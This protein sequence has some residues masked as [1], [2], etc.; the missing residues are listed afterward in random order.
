MCVGNY[1]MELFFSAQYDALFN[2]LYWVALN[3]CQEAENTFW[4]INHWFVISSTPFL[5][6]VHLDIRHLAN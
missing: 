1:N 3:Y 5:L 6:T 2:A 4:N